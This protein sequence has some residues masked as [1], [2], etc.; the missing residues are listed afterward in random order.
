MD[1]GIQPFSPDGNVVDAL[2]SKPLTATSKRFGIGQNNFMA[3]SSDV[4]QRPGAVQEYQRAVAPLEA[5]R[6][7]RLAESADP[8][9]PATRIASDLANQMATGMREN[10]D[11]IGSLRTPRPGYQDA[12]TWNTFGLHGRGQFKTQLGV[13]APVTTYT[14]EPQHT[15]APYGARPE[16]MER[17]GGIA[18]SKT[19]PMVYKD[20]QAMC[21]PGYVMREGRCVPERTEVIC[22]P[23]WHNVNGVCVK[24]DREFQSGDGSTQAD[25]QAQVVAQ[26]IDNYKKPSQALTKDN[27]LSSNQLR[28]YVTEKQEAG[29]VS[30]LS[31]IPFN[32]GDEVFDAT[33]PWINT[34]GVF[35][36]STIVGVLSNLLV[37]FLAMFMSWLIIRDKLF[38]AGY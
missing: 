29:E 28:N 10:P 34:S 36:E 38:E 16:S 6:T 3:F 22:Q 30:E 9:P 8:M 7:Y 21:T 1:K 37:L 19:A 18:A 2:S 13:N 26:A 11:T 20:G 23:G 14:Q 27:A 24:G 32:E 17:Q 4:S 31:G 5:P 35:Y 12:G 33:G 15:L 25:A